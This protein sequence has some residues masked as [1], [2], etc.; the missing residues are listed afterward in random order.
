MK[1]DTR[2]VRDWR[3]KED[4]WKRRARLVARELR[5]GDASSYATFS[6]TTPLAVIKMLVVMSLLHCLSLA[7]IE[8]GDAFLQVPQTSLVLIEIPA[9]ALHAGEDGKG[10]RFWVLKRCLPGQRVAASEWNKFFAEICERQNFESFQGTIFKHRKQMAFISAHIDDLLIVGSKKFIKDFYQNLS[11]EL[12]LKIEGPLQPGDDGSIFYLKREIQVKDDGIDISPSSRYIP[13]LAE[14]LNVQDRRGR[15]VPHHGCL[16]IYD[17]EAT[18]DDQYLNAEDAKLFRSALGICIYVSQERCDIQHSVRVLA[19]YMSKP[20]KV[21]MAAVK[22]LTSYLVHTQDMRL[23]YP[24]VDMNQTTL[25]RWYGGEE[26]Q[27]S[28]PYMLELYSDSDWASCKVS[29]RSTSSGLIFLNSCLIHSHSR[30]QTSVSLSSME[31]EILAATSLLTEAIYVAEA[32]V[33]VS[34]WRQR[35]TWKSRTCHDET[36]LGFHKCAS[37]LFSSWSWK[38]QTSINTI[39]VDTTGDEEEMVLYRS[40]C[41]QGEPCGSQ[42]QGIGKG[43]SRI[44]DETHWTSK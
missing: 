20:T 24:K 43:A 28:K 39:V 42:Y 3:F 7:S 17:P 23:H 15:A 33:A 11:K 22:K 16:Q 6:P 26:R 13:K 31:A 14:L 21:A 25:Q 2:L 9:L 30:S 41:D 5:D 44:S 27:D 1:L 35:R 32:S 18:S 29:R 34:D 8:V 37:F 38:S 36:S 40:H 4:Q 12:K 10:K 19:T